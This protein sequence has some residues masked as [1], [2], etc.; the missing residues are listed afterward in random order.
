MEYI[1]KE[2]PDGSKIRVKDVQNVLLRMLKDVDKICRKHNI[3][4]FLN[5]GSALGAIRHKGFIPWDDDADIA[6]LKDDYLRFIEVLKKALP[7]EYVFQCFE[8]DKRYNPLIPEMKIRKK[9]T[10][11]KEVNTLLENRIKECDGIFLDVFVYDYCSDNKLIDLPF[12]LFNQLLMPLI[13]LFDNININ[14]TWLKSLFVANARFY[15]ILNKNS[16]Y[17]GFDL[18]WTFKNPFKPFIFKKDD[19]YPIQYVDFEDTKLPVAKN[20]HEYLCTAIGKDYNVLPPLEKR[21]PKHIKDIR[22]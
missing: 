10:Y 9:N 18:C 16:K 20:V 4:Y 21:S 3:P 1:L 6:M 5:G 8:V 14:P 7:D 15:G 22:L 11:I 13:I 19:I 12:R 2:N 17:I